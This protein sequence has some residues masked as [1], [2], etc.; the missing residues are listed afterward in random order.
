MI[1]VHVIGLPELKDH[2]QQ[3]GNRM[4]NLNVPLAISAGKAHRNVINHFEKIQSPTGKWRQL[5]ERTLRQRTHGGS[6]PLQDTGK[7]KN[8]VRFKSYKNKAE[9]FTNIIY[10]GVHNY[11]YKKMNIPQR[12]FM[13]L[14]KLTRE[15]IN[16]TIG[17]F[18]VRG[19]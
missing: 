11:G 4:L 6:K 5:T 16:K 19:K 9:V 12:E 14:D 2:I 10:A 7:L 13:W 3:L 18:I 17:S 15:S 1:N 8:S